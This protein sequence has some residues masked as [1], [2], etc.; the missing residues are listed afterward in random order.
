MIINLL[1]KEPLSKFI[2]SPSDLDR[3]TLVVLAGYSIAGLILW[4]Y[5]YG[6]C[7]EG[8]RLYKFEK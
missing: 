6:R 5:A 1:L 3:T 2:E 7:K 8:C 4:I